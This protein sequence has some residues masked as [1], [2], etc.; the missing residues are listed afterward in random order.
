MKDKELVAVITG[1]G[2]LGGIGAATAERLA[3]QGYHLVLNCI[4][5]AD[6]IERVAQKCRA[7]SV[8]V[9]VY[10]GDLTQESICR[11]LAQ[12]TLNTFGRIDVLVN[13]LGYSKTT[14][15]DRLDLIDA[16]IFEQTFKINTLAPFLVAKA[17]HSMLRESDQAVIVNISSTSGLT[18]KSSSLPYS[19]AKGGLNTLT[20]VLAQAMSPEVRV[21]AVCPSFVDSSWYRDREPAKLD[22]IRKSIAENNLLHR[23]LVPDDVAKVIMSIIDNPAMTGELIKIDAGAHIGKG[24]PR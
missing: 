17:F 14:P 21:N 11:E 1:A 12:F 22:A 23:V 6:E 18:G 7:H 24:N 8:K 2:R 4:N 5:S 13:A 9:E 15:T 10:I 3:Q 19:V 16:E 20:L